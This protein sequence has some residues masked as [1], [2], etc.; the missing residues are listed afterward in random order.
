MENFFKKLGLDVVIPFILI[1]LL[2]VFFVSYNQMR[3]KV[4]VVHSYYTDYSWVKELNAG[5]EKVFKDFDLI[6]VE[7]FYMDTKRHHQ[8]HFKEQTGFEARQVIN[9]LKPD[10][11]IV[12]DDDAQNHVTTHYKNHPTISFVFAG[13]NADIEEY[14]FDKANNITGI[15]ERLPLEGVKNAILEMVGPL[16]AQ[17]PIR[18]GHVSSAVLTVKLDD[19]YIHQYKKWDKIVINP[20]RLVNTFPEWKK[21]ILDAAND[22]DFIIIS[23]CRKLMRS[24][25]DNTFV[26]PTEIMTWTAE[27][28]KV[29]IIG[30]NSFIVE[31]GGP[32]A[33]STSAIEQGEVAAK[34][35]LKIIIDKI[36]VNQ[37][38]IQKAREFII[39]MRPELM[40]KFSMTLPEIYMASA[41]ISRT[42]FE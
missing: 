22:L 29:P 34:L 9:R 27:N 37:L 2:F 40:K 32:F 7:Y 39:S 18:V 19:T 5:L 13:V 10:I 26:S 11:V 15:L 30:V 6:K 24:H 23:N 42:Y 20:S 1:L 4:L 14:G 3:K 31:D 8:E 16:K 33:V 25:N 36:P 41:R 17:S 21:A 28:S 38:P 35:A 12:C